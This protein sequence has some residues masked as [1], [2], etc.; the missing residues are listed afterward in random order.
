MVEEGVACVY[1]LDV[2]EGGEKRD[3]VAECAMKDNY[4]AVFM[5]HTG[6]R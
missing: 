1:R 4:K 3:F 2:V 5:E 6:R